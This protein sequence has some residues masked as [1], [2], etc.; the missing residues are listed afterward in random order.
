ME[1]LKQFLKTQGPAFFLAL[2][3]VIFAILLTNLLYQPK[4]IIKRGFEI[5]I[6]ADGKPII[7]KEEKPIDLVTLLKT[8]DFDRGMKTFKKCASCHTIGKGEA[9]KVGPNLYGII[10]RKRGSFAGFAYSKAMLAKGGSW[11]AEEINAFITKPKE[12]L[13]GTKMGFAGLKKP[14]DRADVIL[15]LEKQK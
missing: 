12:Y 1:K 2:G 6:S 8:A 10:G 15:Y 3:L 13:P 14:Q 5:A 9:A 4:S 11:N 7:K